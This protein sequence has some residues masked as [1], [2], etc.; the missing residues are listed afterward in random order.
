MISRTRGTYTDN[1]GKKHHTSRPVIDV[2]HYF[3]RNIPTTYRTRWSLARCTVRL[4]C[5]VLWGCFIFVTQGI[6]SFFPGRARVHYPRFFW[7]V[8]CRILGIDIRVIGENIGRYNSRRSVRNGARPVVY[9]SNHSSWI[10]ILV[11]GKLLPANFVAKNQVKTWPLIG[12]LSRVA[13]SIFI[14]RNRQEA[15]SEVNDVIRRLH[16]GDNIVFFPEGTTSDGND[17]LPFFS[18]IFAITKPVPTRR[19]KSDKQTSGH[20]PDSEA[21]NGKSAAPLTP[22]PLLVQPVSI[23]YDRVENL[24]VGR[25]R[26]LSVF[27]WFGDMDLM[28]H[29]VAF[30]QW[31]SVRASVYFHPPLDPEAFASRKLLSLKAY[32]I[33]RQGHEALRQNRIP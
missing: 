18:T 22:P 14:S 17:V 9:A 7:K 1:T 3:P 2:E 25:S 21:G 11:L 27:S 12:P 28:P 13:R 31:R 23:V 10:D 29:L 8:T 30:G 15:N 6:L 32:D 26:R 4:S 33:I 20:S 24:P 5:F 16:Q 19:P